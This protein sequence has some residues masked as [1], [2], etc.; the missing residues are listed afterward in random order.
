MVTVKAK[1]DRLKAL[2]EQIV[3]LIQKLTYWNNI[4]FL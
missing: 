2:T 1:K 3:V 4:I